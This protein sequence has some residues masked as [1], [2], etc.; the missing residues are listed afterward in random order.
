MNVPAVPSEFIF[1]FLLIKAVLAILAS[2]LFFYYKYNWERAKKHLPIHFFYTR[3]RS[4]KH[5]IILGSAALG[6]AVGFTLEIFG[7]GAGLSADM[8]RLISSFFE[9]GALF[10]MLFVFFELVME[11]VPQ[12]Q[13]IAESARRPHH[14]D[15]SFAQPAAKPA[16]ARKRRRKRR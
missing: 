5:A 9:V 4:A 6:F 13:H 7:Q 15:K 12:L 11:D 1:P 2:L 10:F 16:A 8:A 3:W 14:V